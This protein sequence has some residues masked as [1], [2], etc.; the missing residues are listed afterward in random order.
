MK[1][2]NPFL[3]L[4]Y[5]INPGKVIAVPKLWAGGGCWGYFNKAP[6]PQHILSTKAQTL[7]PI[8]TAFGDY[9]KKVEILGSLLP[10]ELS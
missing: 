9:G 10:S 4:L 3:Q 5:Y 1:L 8:A 6:E 2:S 7:G